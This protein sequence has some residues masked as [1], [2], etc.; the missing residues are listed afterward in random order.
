MLRPVRSTQGID[1]SRAGRAASPLRACIGVLAFI[2]CGF[3]VLFAIGVAPA[4]A[5]EPNIMR[6]KKPVVWH[7]QIADNSRGEVEST[8]E[9]VE[10]A[11]Y[12]ASFEA[13]GGGDGGEEYREECE[14][15]NIFE[16]CVGLHKVVR[17]NTEGELPKGY[18]KLEHLAS[19]S[20][21]EG[22]RTVV[23]GRFAWK[24]DRRRPG[25]RI[26]ELL[27]L[28]NS[29]EP[30]VKHHCKGEPVNCQTGDLVESQTDLQ[31]PAL[32]VPFALERTYNSQ[33]AS[34]GSPADIFGHGWSS[35]FGD[36]LEIDSATGEITVVQ[37]NGSTV[38]FFGEVG[39]AG[40]FT[41]PGWGQAR[42]V[43]TSEGQYKYTLPDQETF[44]FGS[45]GRLFE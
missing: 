33:A 17:K 18:I 37:A 19:E 36:H 22:I 24:P 4:D 38:V 35:S 43:Y 42:L 29:A 31:V 6:A 40:T 41:G 32:G 12:Y 26:T 23:K 27:G 44:T 14:T 21:Y 16:S 15:G 45:S 30:D 10:P 28:A 7:E 2:A 5:A 39:T 34:E 25:P 3:A 1:L 11:G 8:P 13:L 9:Y 20:E